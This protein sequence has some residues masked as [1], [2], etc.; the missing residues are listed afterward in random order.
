MPLVLRRSSREDGQGNKEG[1]DS[2]RV[3]HERFLPRID[4]NALM[5]ARIRSETPRRKEQSYD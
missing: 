2:E 4:A 3:F 1:G 5:A